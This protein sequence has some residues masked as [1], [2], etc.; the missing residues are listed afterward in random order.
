MPPTSQTINT[1][2]CQKS[3]CPKPTETTTTTP[4]PNDVTNTPEPQKTCSLI[5]CAGA[6]DPVCARFG[7][8]KFFVYK[9]MCHLRKL[10]CLAS[11]TVPVTYD[12][13][14]CGPATE[15]QESSRPCDS[16]PI[17]TEIR[18]NRQQKGALCTYAPKRMPSC[19]KNFCK[20]A[21]KET[22]SSLCC[23]ALTFTG[24]KVVFEGTCDNGT[25]DN[26][27]VEVP[28]TCGCKDVKK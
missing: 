10:Q 15:N 4:K 17:M 24:E 25:F 2:S 5:M 19:E 21:G 18:P 12:K 27:V 14:K 11:K 20:L 23:I 16:G 6:D 1:R 8:G 7:D 26:Y 28:A 9:S 13:T 22:P 3:G